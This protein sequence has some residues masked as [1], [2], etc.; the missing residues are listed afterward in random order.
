MK[1]WPA[2][3]HAMNLEIPDEQLVGIATAL[4]GLDSAFA[5]LRTGIAPGTDPASIFRAAIEEAE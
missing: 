5:P 4:D 2:I 1:N 3:S